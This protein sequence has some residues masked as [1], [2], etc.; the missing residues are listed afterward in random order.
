MTNPAQVVD[1]LRGIRSDLA[2]NLLLADLD[3]CLIV[4]DLRVG[5]GINVYG[6]ERETY[7]ITLSTVR[8]EVDLTSIL[9]PGDAAEI[10]RK[11]REGKSR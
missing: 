4:G 1:Q 8:G 9:P 5:I 6:N 3:A 11:A 2:P 10:E 7:R